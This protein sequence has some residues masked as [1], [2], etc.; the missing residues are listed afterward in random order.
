MHNVQLSVENPICDQC[1]SSDLEITGW[2]Y[3]VAGYN[4]IIV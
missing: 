1:P 2:E 4:L 3:S